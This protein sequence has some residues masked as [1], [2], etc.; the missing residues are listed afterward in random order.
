MDILH[1]II[2]DKLNVPHVCFSVF[3]FLWEFIQKYNAWPNQVSPAQNCV[4][5]N[6]S[7]WRQRAYAII[8][9]I[10]LTVWPLQSPVWLIRKRAKNKPFG[11]TRWREGQRLF[12]INKQKNTTY[13]DDRT[14]FT[15]CKYTKS[16]QIMKLLVSVHRDRG[17][18][19]IF[20]VPVARLC[21]C[22]LSV[23]QKCSQLWFI[24]F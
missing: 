8:Y 6:C 20:S 17:K 2:T 13:K 16:F 12:T 19:F 4:F 3:V 18:K 22:W 9:S 11:R 21:K 7:A 5:S 14:S 10:I 15:D 24:F 1:H 23:E